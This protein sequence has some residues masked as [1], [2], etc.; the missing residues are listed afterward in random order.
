MR[1]GR[2]ELPGVVDEYR[3]RLLPLIVPITLLRRHLRRY[4]DGCT[5][6]QYFLDPDPRER[7]LHNLV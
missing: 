4:P 6:R 7:M 2:R 5:E 3:R 1:G